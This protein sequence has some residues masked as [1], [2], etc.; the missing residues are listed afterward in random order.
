MPTDEGDTKH[1]TELQLSLLQSIFVRDVLT[2][3]R[4]IATLNGPLG[5]MNADIR[6]RDIRKRCALDDWRV[7][8]FRRELECLV[9]LC[10]EHRQSRRRGLDLWLTHRQLEQRL[11]LHPGW[12]GG[13]CRRRL[14]R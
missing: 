5:V 12:Q 7:D 4:D 8:V 2:F 6:G 3:D 14:T 9:A 13:Q 11:Q 10:N 1:T